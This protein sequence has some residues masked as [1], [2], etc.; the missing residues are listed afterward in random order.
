MTAKIRE[1]GGGATAPILCDWRAFSKNL[2]AKIWTISD[3]S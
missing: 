1:D 3:G 2:A